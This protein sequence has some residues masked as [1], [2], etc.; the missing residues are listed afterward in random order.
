MPAPGSARDFRL[1]DPAYDVARA[2]EDGE[3]DLAIDNTP[4]PKEYLRI[5]G[6]YTDEVVCM[7]R[8]DHPLA[9][10]QQL[11]L[12]LYLTL[13][14]LAPH[15]S[16]TRHLGVIDSELAKVGYRRTITATVPEFNLAPYVL[17]RSDLVFTT[18][19]SFA[20]FY[21]RTLRLRIMPA[22]REFPPIQFYQLWHER[23]QDSVS[24]RW[25]RKQ[26]LDVV[27]TIFEGRRASLPAEE[28]SDV[29]S[30]GRWL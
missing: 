25:L 13:N 27:K 6:L 19:R 10:S 3:L 2:L 8:D 4:N 22:P 21:A 28:A 18:G 15:P 5:G 23:A 30:A 1:I 11:E 12:A 16:T 7:M 29:Q 14:H 9:S 17:I 26:A 24:N 20:E